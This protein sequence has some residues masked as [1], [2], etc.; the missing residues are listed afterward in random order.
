EI[1]KGMEAMLTGWGCHVLTAATL[2]EVIDLIDKQGR[3]PDGIIADYHLDSGTGIDVI[4]ECRKLCNAD[5]HSIIATA[6][7]SRSVQTFAEERNIHILRKPLKP[8]ALRALL[9]QWRARQIAAE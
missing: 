5:L 1:L 7:R 3:T 9:S 6:D 2:E 8:A 4:E